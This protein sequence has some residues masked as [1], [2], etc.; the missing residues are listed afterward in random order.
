MNHKKL[1]CSDGVKSKETS[2]VLP[3]WP[4]PLG[5]FLSGS[6]FH[7][8]KFLTTL[9]HLYDKINIEGYDPTQLDLETLAFAKMVHGHSVVRQNDGAILF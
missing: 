4:Q 3:D 5:V 7:P 8:L 2:D 6:H 9:R 1:H